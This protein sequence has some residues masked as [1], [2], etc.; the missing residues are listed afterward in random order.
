MGVK[1]V[2]RIVTGRT[3]SGSTGNDFIIE[4]STSLM[5]SSMSFSS[6][7]NEDLEA[8]GTQSTSDNVGQML[9]EPKT[10]T[11]SVK[12]K[13]LTYSNVINLMKPYA[14]MVS[15][16]SLLKQDALMKGFQ[17]LYLAAMM[18]MSNNCLCVENTITDHV[19]AFKSGNSK[20]LPG[21][22]KCPPE[23]LVRVCPH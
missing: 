17:G 18:V 13:K 15:S 11:N 20:I 7:V 5:E 2:R 19:C 1:S 6:P 22:R 14:E 4:D 12:R 8:F 10:A 9:C 21:N 16:A 3:N 23:S